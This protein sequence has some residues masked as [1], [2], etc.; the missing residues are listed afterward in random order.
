MELLKLNKEIKGLVKYVIE[1]VL[2]SINT[3]EKHKIKE[4]IECLETRYGRTI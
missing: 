4:V 1:N 2:M 3:V